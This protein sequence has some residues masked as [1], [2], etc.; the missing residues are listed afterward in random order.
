MVDGDITYT[1]SV[2]A[3]TSA[4][5]NYDGRDPD[6][7]SVTNLDDDSAG[8]SVSAI[9]GDTDESGTSATFSVVLA[10]QPSAPVSIEITNGD[11]TEGRLR[12]SPLIFDGA[13]WNVAQTVTVTGVDDFVVDGDI[14]Y[15][16]SVEAA[17]SADAN[18]DGRDPDDVSVTNLDDDS[19]GVTVSA[20]SG[21]TDESGTSATFSVVLNSQPSAPVSIE[22][23]S[24]DMTEG[25][26]RASPLIFDGANWNVAQTVTVTGVND[27]VVDGDIT[28]TVSVEAATSADT[29][30]D[31]LDPDDVSVTN[32]DDDSA[33]VSVSA[34]S[35][36]TDET[37]TRP[38]S[39]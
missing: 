30:Y 25:S 11:M 33:G 20:I 28:Y 22:I 21:D 6:D 26:L 13:N 27:F 34:I 14:T 3:A 8:V 19:A 23:T 38:P 4:D 10:S 29:N 17:T 32:L 36:N 12:A 31:G 16:V 24:G 7:V 9:S 18:Y 2:E 15:T 5:A 35:G 39:P 37:G 1:V